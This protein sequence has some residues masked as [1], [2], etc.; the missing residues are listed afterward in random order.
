M[1]IRTS[2]FSSGASHP[3]DLADRASEI[4]LAALALT[5]RDGLYG[6]VRFS[7]RARSHGLAAIVGSELTFE[8]GARIVLLV[9]DARGYANL[10]EAIFNGADARKQG[11]RSSADR[12]SRAV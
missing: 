8:D 5:D 12:G 3:E 11:R 4:G 1:R 6:S 2:P 9:E 7:T 10:C